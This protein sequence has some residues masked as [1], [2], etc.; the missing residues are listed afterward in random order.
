MKRWIAFWSIFVKDLRAYYLKPPNVSWGLIFPLTWIV[1]VGTLPGVFIGYYFRILYLPDPR[2][3]K[4]FVGCVLL[5][6]GGRLLYEMTPHSQRE[7]QE[8]KILDD[9]FN[10]HVK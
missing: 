4:L 2:S 7:K 1:I 5:F 6:I 3:F 8:M 9:K 10:Q